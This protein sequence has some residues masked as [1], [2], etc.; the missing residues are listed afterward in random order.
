MKPVKRGDIFYADLNV[1]SS[2]SEQ[3]GNRPVIIIQND[4]GNLFSPTV[5]V[6]ILTSK[7]KKFLPTHINIS[8]GEGN[9][10]C[11]S[12]VLLEQI[13]TIDK[14]RLVKYIGRVTDTTMDKINQAMLLS[15]GLK[16]T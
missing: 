10:A 13:K 16:K 3:S 12:I 9:L 11:D 7:S 6:A 8:S 15:L 4:I 1:H 2:G 14:T 5:I